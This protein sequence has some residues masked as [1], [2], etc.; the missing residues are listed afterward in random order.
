MCL[1][2]SNKI[3]SLSIGKSSP[4]FQRLRKGFYI[5]YQSKTWHSAM[6]GKIARI[7]TITKHFQRFANTTAFHTPCNVRKSAECFE[8]TAKLYKKKKCKLTRHP[9]QA[10][11]H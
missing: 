4:E 3:Y 9:R 10:I 11:R 8:Q 5:N 6:T 1:R 2:K 7:G